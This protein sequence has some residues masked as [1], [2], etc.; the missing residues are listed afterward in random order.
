MA[1]NYEL[2]RT[3]RISRPGVDPEVVVFTGTMLGSIAAVEVQAGSALPRSKAARQQFTMDLF[4]MGIE[5]DPA[6]VREEL[7][8][9]SEEPSDYQ[10]AMAQADRENFRMQ[11]GQPQNV[12][13]W[14][15]H[16][17][18]IARHRRFMM[19]KDYEALTEP[20]KKIFQDHDVLHQKF[21][22][23]VAQASQ[24]GVP[25]PGQEFPPAQGGAPAGQFAPQ[26]T[27]QSGGGGTPTN[28]AAP[29][30]MNTVPQ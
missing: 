18:H 3:D 25:T 10:L 29:T 27:T 4:S 15:N 6:K 30:Q 13:E 26:G 19:S 1:E 24:M 12:E 21:L 22:T 23:G 17:A 14:Y 5:Q 28:G 20:N 16:Q 9:G 11:N 8:L 7:E 2:P